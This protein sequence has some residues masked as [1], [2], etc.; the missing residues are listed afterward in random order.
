MPDHVALQ[1]M[2]NLVRVPPVVAQKVL[3]TVGSGGA[4]PVR[5]L[6]QPFLR[7]TGLSS[8]VS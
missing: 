6:R 7:S 4:S 3:Q 8:R 1:F 5:Q 2:A